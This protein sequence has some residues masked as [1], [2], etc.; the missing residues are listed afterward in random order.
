MHLA[1]DML[2][3]GLVVLVS[4][5]G[6]HVLLARA[7]AARRP[8]P[9]LPDRWPSL[10]IV[11]PIRGVDEGLEANLAA[12]LGSDYPGELETVFVLDDASDPAL[13]AVQR[14]IEQH[15]RAG[16]RGRAEILFAGAP[17]PSMTGKLN[18]MATGL[19]VARGEL[20]AF[21]D[22]DTRPARHLLRD[23]VALLLSDPNGGDVFVP[24]VVRNRARTAGDAAYALLINGWY[25]PAA[26]LAARRAHG[27][28]PFIMGQLMIFRRE[29]LRAVG[30]VECA[31]GQLV[32]DM[33]LGRCVA[34][35]G[36]RNLMSDDRLD[37][38]TGGMTLAEFVRLFRRWLLF[39]K[40]GLPAGFTAPHWARGL[41][42]WAAALGLFT[43]VTAG[44]WLAA[45]PALLALAAFVASQAILQRRFGGA[46]LALRQLWTTLLIPVIAP[47]AVLEVLFDHSVSWRGRTYAVD[48]AHARLMTDARDARHE[49]PDAHSARY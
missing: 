22:S 3:I 36:W 6:L 44:E 4:I 46:P 16:G 33:Y 26:A 43:T 38:A 8:A 47:F 9:A 40:N 15:E 12:A 32:D 7:L 41:Q 19:A 28:L 2:P 21:G 35:A 14:A 42:F 1:E 48:T 39:S 34:K 23:M 13:P 11:R 27:H 29:A 20:V 17:P 5:L 49:A 30:G 25:G 31:A 45:A 37:I 10:S 24:V 18:A